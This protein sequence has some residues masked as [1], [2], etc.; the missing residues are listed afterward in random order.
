VQYFL[1][2]SMLH[3][4]AIGMMIIVM[5]SFMTIVLIPLGFLV[6][7]LFLLYTSTTAVLSRE[8]VLNDFEENEEA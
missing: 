8:I 3:L 2:V 1:M 5:F 4:S 6:V 7:Y